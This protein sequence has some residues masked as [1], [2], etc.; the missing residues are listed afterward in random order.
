MTE[1]T[2]DSAPH[3][4]SATAVLV[5]ASLGLAA[6]WWL[7]QNFTPG[8]DGCCPGPA[9]DGTRA[10]GA[11]APSNATTPRPATQTRTTS[12]GAAGDGTASAPAPAAPEAAVAPKAPSMPKSK[13]KAAKA[14]KAK[15]RRASAGDDLTRIEGI[16][17]KM[18]SV[19]ADAGV[20]SYAELAG[21]TPEGLRDLL[22]SINS[23]Y[24]MFD[25]ETWPEQAALAAAGRFDDLDALQGE[26]KGGRRT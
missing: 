12:E 18:A 2:E 9:A 17:P 22:A 10:D 5:G 11:E 13:T 26:L 3:R 23:R 8:P 15:T 24:R 7:R 4:F 20:D 6:M 1:E 25:P 16:G 19:L 14:T 21:R